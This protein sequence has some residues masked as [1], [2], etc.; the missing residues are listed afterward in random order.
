MVVSRKRRN[1]GKGELDSKRRAETSSVNI[2]DRISAAVRSGGLR[3]Q[4]SVFKTW[5]QDLWLLNPDRARLTLDGLLTQQ[6]TY[7]EALLCQGIV[8]RMIHSWCLIAYERRLITANRG[9]STRRNQKETRL[10]LRTRKLGTLIVEIINELFA[11]PEVGIDAY[12]ICAALAGR[13]QQPVSNYGLLTSISWCQRR[14]PISNPEYLPRLIC[15]PIE[16]YC[17]PRREKPNCRSREVLDEHRTKTCA[18]P[19]CPDHNDGPLVSP[20]FAK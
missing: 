20:N 9:K 1:T 4:P 8:A 18:R 12:K 3:Y 13:Y 16:G 17:P 14:R 5:E 11:Q 15:R 7:T 10:S 6:R 19:S 2:A